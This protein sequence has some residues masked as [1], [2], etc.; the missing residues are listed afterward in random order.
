[1]ENRFSNLSIILHVV[2]TTATLACIV[3]IT[4][5]LLRTSSV[6]NSSGAGGKQ[7]SSQEAIGGGYESD[8]PSQDDHPS[9]H[10]GSWS[11]LVRDVKP[12]IFRI[13]LTDE[14]SLVGSGS[15]FCVGRDLIVTNSHEDMNDNN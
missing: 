11:Q 2:N 14:D 9:Q 5:L 4:V 12:S 15:G 1:M 13:L 10:S 3:L 6:G 8:P 7:V